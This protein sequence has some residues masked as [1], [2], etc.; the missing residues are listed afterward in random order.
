MQSLN[1]LYLFASGGIQLIFTINQKNHKMT[2]GEKI[3]I[4]SKKVIN[5]FSINSYNKD[6]FFEASVGGYVTQKVIF[7][8]LGKN[9]LQDLQLKNNFKKLIEQIKFQLMM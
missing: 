3:V 9:G 5:E 4:S 1:A 2:Q 7:D 8:F 6:G